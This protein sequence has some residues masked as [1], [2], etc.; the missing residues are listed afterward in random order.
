MKPL[1]LKRHL[2]T[3]HTVLK[4][5]LVDQWTRTTAEHI[6]QQLTGLSERMNWI[7]KRV[8]TDCARA[9]TGHHNI[10]PEMHRTQ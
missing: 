9:M 4:D 7:G 10:A 5:K 6:F 2:T 1:H 3:K 8:C